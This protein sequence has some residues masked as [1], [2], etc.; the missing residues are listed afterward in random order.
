LTL[1]SKNITDTSAISSFAYVLDPTG[2]RTKMSIAGS[3]YTSADIAYAYDDAN[4]LTGELRTGGNAY[5]QY[6]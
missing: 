6:F 2:N 4:Q 1:L 5:T 3:A